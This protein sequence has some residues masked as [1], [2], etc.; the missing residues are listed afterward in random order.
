MK[1]KSSV[2][3]AIIFL[4]L[5]LQPIICQPANDDCATGA[6]ALDLGVRYFGTNVGSTPDGGWSRTCPVNVFDFDSVWFTLNVEQSTRIRVETCQ[7]EIDTILFMY[8]G[9]CSTLACHAFNDNGDCSPQSS[10]QTDVAPFS[11]YII[12]IMGANGAKGRFSIL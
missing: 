4:L 9:T 5:Q 1:T 12:L 6:I 11:T 8:T 10:F 2:F 3:Y 7:S